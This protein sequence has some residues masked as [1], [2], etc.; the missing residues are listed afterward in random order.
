MD[1]FK[2]DDFVCVMGVWINQEMSKSLAH[3]AN[4]LL[5]ERGKIAT[6]Y[7]EKREWY[8]DGAG[9]SS[10]DTHIALLINIEPIEVD[11]AEKIVTDLAKW[12]DN[13]IGCVI[14]YSGNKPFGLDKIIERAKKLLGD[15]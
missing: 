12:Q 15:K 2:D 4:R 9:G 14:T 1:F 10:M 3:I 7:G 5:K 8:V 6:S 13:N 11:S